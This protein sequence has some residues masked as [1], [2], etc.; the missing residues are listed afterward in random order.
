MPI[1]KAQTTTLKLAADNNGYFVPSTS[2]LKGGAIQK[3]TTALI[4]KALLEPETN[5]GYRITDS[6]KKAIGITA[7]KQAPLEA[8]KGTKTEKLIKMLRRKNGATNAQIQEAL[9]WQA[10]SVRGII[11]GTVKKKMRLEVTAEKNK[12]GDLAY[13]IMN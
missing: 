11:S 3:V 10:H 1:S 2:P 9:N 4:N 6:G 12:S 5:K 7:E 13:K 8:R